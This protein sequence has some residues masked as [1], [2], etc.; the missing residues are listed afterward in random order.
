MLRHA[1]RLSLEGLV[2]KLADAPYRS[3]RSKDWRKSKCSQRQEFVIG[4]YVPSTVSSHAIG[5]LV[6]GVFED[7]KLRHVGRVGTGY[8]ARVAADLWKRLQPLVRDKSPFAGKLSAE[9][10]R[11]V[12]FVEPSLVAE[13]E[14]RS[15]TGDHNLRHAAYRGLRE[16]KPAVDVVQEGAPQ[17]NADRPRGS[18]VKLTHPDRIYWPEDGVTKQGAGGLLHA[19]LGEDRPFIVAR[20]LALLRCPDG[21]AQACFFQKHAWRGINKAV[22]LVPDPKDKGGEPLLTIS[23]FD[24]L[25]ALVQ[26]GTLEIHPW[27]APLAGLEKPDMLIFDLDPGPGVGWPEVIDAAKEVRA[28]LEADGMAAF[29]KTSGGKGLHVVTPLAPKAGWAPAKDYA[30]AVADRMAADDPGRFISVATKAKRGG[31][32]FV[33]YLRNARGATAVAPYS[34]RA[35]AGAAVSMP[36]TWEELDQL[37]SAA[38]Y[39]VDNAPTRLASLDADPWEDFR[40]AAKPLPAGKKR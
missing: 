22:K 23:D 1:C 31:R 39:T 38:Q 9:A 6:M 40:A 21:I 27:G 12:H 34:T 33:D 37:A 8:T 3:G 2:S 5:S 29:V 10:A 13:V 26:A 30:K 16:D 19:G 14:F 15:W 35:R 25:I 17:M 36:V 20:P 18:S 24:G 28:R 4:G 7:G 32:I 11:G